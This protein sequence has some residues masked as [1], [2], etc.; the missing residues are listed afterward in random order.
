MLA[1]GA[2]SRLQ[3]R[4]QPFHT[5]LSVGKTYKTMWPDGGPIEDGRGDSISPE[6]LVLGEANLTLET[7]KFIA[8]LFLTELAM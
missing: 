2:C 1:C 5:G 4:V 6:T 8:K 7:L 3:V